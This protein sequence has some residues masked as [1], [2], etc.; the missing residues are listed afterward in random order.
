MTVSSR[1]LSLAISAL[2]AINTAAS[3]GKTDPIYRLHRTI[4][5]EGKIQRNLQEVDSYDGLY[6][7]EDW[8]YHLADANRKH[9]SKSC[10]GKGRSCAPTALPSAVPSA[11][12]TI[13]TAP[14]SLPSQAPSQLPSQ[15]P[16]ELPSA[17]PTISTM[18]SKQ[19]S[20][21]PSSIPSAGPSN[22]P[23][24]FPSSPPSPAPTI[25][26]MPTEALY[27]TE[28]TGGLVTRC[29]Q[30]PPADS[31]VF[32]EQTLAFQYNLYTIPDAAFSEEMAILEA[33][34]HDGLSNEFLKCKYQS[35]K[36][37]EP[38]FHIVSVSAKPDDSLGDTVCDPTNDSTPSEESKCVVVNAELTMTA[39]FPSSSR[40]VLQTGSTDAN[41]EVLESTGDFLNTAMKN[42]D[43]ETDDIVQVSFQGFVNAQEGG[44]ETPPSSG[45]GS[46]IAG[47]IGGNPPVSNVTDNRVALGGAVVGLAAVV[48]M[49]VLFTTS[50]RR[51][52]R[53][54]AYL[55]HL[56]AISVSDMGSYDEGRKSR[57]VLG[58]GRVHLVLDNSE[59]INS[60]G[61][62]S[63]VDFIL[64]DL[65]TS[66][67]S[68][69]SS[70]SRHDVHTCS[71]ATCP[72]CRA[73]EQNPTFIRTPPSQGY[74]FSQ[75]QQSIADIRDSY[76]SPDTVAL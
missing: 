2:L 34:I 73:R 64:R 35:K 56:E 6:D 17:G 69:M 15:S 54:D 33:S 37:D 43:F 23:T 72:I 71:S 16:S 55:E 68:R 66:G 4:S 1:K 11:F 50:R 53:Q 5:K 57:E 70:A 14:S 46:G 61:D 52:R 31:G 20:E 26:P 47:V 28:R 36:K 44:R 24:Q 38:S 49:I 41:T 13:S 21:A 76:R 39:Y 10:G 75:W 3:H 19:P 40:R 18:P 29:V 32:Q 62:G 25:S 27:Q 42:G 58:D 7:A 22:F 59:M 8:Q 60:S 51:K 30:Q 48:L 45:G 9:T 63:T 12:P 65:D 67:V 74:S